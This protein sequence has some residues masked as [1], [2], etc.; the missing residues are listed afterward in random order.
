MKKNYLKPAIRLV[1][2]KHQRHILAGSYAN[3]TPNNAGFDP[4]ITGSGGTSRS[5]S[6]DDLD[7]WE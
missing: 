7:D 4:N 3:Q 2:L 6:L 1:V 5:R